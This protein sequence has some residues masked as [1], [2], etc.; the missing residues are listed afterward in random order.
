MVNFQS[1]SKSQYIWWWVNK[2]KGEQFKKGNS[3][4]TNVYIEKNVIVDLNSYEVN[5]GGEF[6]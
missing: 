1:H 4:Q 6:L 5:I 2:D 3:K